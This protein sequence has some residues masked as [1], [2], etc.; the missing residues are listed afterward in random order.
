M[1]KVFFTLSALFCLVANHAMAI[2]A[3]AEIRNQRMSL[4][5]FFF[6]IYLHTENNE[7]LYLGN[8]D[9]VLS[10]E[11]AKF[12]SPSFSFLPGSTGLFN[13]KGD[14]TYF[15]NNTIGTRLETSGFNAYKLSILV[16]LP[17]Y[18]NKNNFLDRIA[19]I[20]S[21][22]YTHRLGTF[23]ITGA[24]ELNKPAKL[25]WITSGKGLKLLVNHRDSADFS[26]QE[27]NMLPIPAPV[28]LNPPTTQ[29]KLN[30]VAINSYTLELNWTAGDGN[31][32]I[33][34]IQEDSAITQVPGNN[35]TYLAS[36]NYKEGDRIG[37]SHA[38]VAS[39]GTGSTAV[40]GNLNS[41]TTYHFAL[42][43]YNVDERGWSEVYLGSQPDTLS[44][45][46]N[47][48]YITAELKVFI[49][50][51]YNL[52]LG[53]MRTDLRTGNAN[54]KNNLLPRNQPYS[55]APW[56]YAGAEFLDTVNHAPTAVDWVL[57]E[58]RS[59]ATGTAVPNGRVA[60]FLHSDGRI[61]DVNGVDPLR[62]YNVKPDFYF[63][64]VRH[65]NHLAIMSADSVELSPTSQLYDFTTDASKAFGSG[66]K[67]LGN[68]TFA[69]FAGDANADG[70]VK[71]NNT[72]ADRFEILNTVGLDNPN[73]VIKNIYSGSDVNMDR[74]VKY[75]GASADRVYT[76][77]AIGFADPDAILNQLVP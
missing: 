62:F 7:G 64:D 27:V 18:S 58:L 74:L 3:T 38:Y 30:V 25:D 56:N 28:P 9:F 57:V 77:K 52:T 37:S 23:Y 69:A 31:E 61:L 32:R 36:T 65:R 6:D 53:K 22:T 47:Q 68:G 8:S 49:E 5:T 50:G 29:G 11:Q 13:Q 19:R 51:A 63:L 2:D 55:A 34:L 15:Y 60:G 21:R 75:N 70:M 16:N 72:G 44:V 67:N 39:I 76:L 41:N 45:T 46:T 14:S 4:D 12:N 54:G 42:F 48:G 66:Q 35:L 33:L 20:D 10:F 26:K 1:K 71:Y 59:T 73:R 24:Q 43:E 17:N 40:I